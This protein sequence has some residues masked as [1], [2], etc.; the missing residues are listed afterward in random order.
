DHVGGHVEA[1]DDGLEGCVVIGIFGGGADDRG[2]LLEL[3]I[4][5]AGNAIVYDIYITGES[6]GGA[7]R[8]VVDEGAKIHG[9]EF[10]IGIAF[11]VV[12]PGLEQFQLGRGVAAELERRI[13][14]RLEQRICLRIDIVKAIPFVLDGIAVACTAAVKVFQDGEIIGE[15][16]WISDH[17]A[18]GLG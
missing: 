16:G 4:G 17:G 13:G 1:G 12:G 18:I 9:A 7:V 14:Q 15:A 3:A 8:G 11:P 6:F 2:G 10:G 5:G